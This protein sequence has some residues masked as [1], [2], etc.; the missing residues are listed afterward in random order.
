MIEFPIR[1]TVM[2]HGKVKGM[3]QID[4]DSYHQIHKITV[5]KGITFLPLKMKIM[6]M[7]VEYELEVHVE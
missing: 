5:S 3:C 7:Q 2:N 1:P 6:N 4:F